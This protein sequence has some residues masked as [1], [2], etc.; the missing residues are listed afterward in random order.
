MAKKT[1]VDDIQRLIKSAEE[2][3]SKPI[4]SSVASDVKAFEQQVK[5]QQL[6]TS[7]QSKS[8]DFDT[9][10]A[11]FKVVSS[12]VTDAFYDF[13]AKIPKSKQKDFKHI[14]NRIAN[15][16][17]T[18]ATLYTT[19]KVYKE[20]F[21]QA[22]EVLRSGM[23]DEKLVKALTELGKQ[24]IEALKAQENYIMYIEELA[25]KSGIEV[26]DILSAEE[27]EMFDDV[28]GESN[29]V[30]L[31]P[32]NKSKNIVNASKEFMISSDQ[33]LLLDNCKSSNT[34]THE[35]VTEL[36]SDR[37]KAFGDTDRLIDPS[38]K[39][40]L[41]SEFGVDASLIKSNAPVD[42]IDSI[43]MDMM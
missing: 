10:E 3:T 22:G 38:Q 30:K 34:Y 14:Y 9:S 4:I 1:H 21:K 11:A 27:M 7:T 28:T 20:I 29:G 6:I 12:E 2:V 15:C 42:D 23:I 19:T 39:G 36:R 43:L 33:R 41:Q 32:D 17:S 25:K 18:L 40:M 37:Y 8:L 5:E 16:K 31:L 13:Y 24:Q 26:R 35:E